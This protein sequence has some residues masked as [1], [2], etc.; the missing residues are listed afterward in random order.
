LKQDAKNANRGTKRGHDAISQSLK[1][2]GA[3]RS[4]LVDKNGVIVAGNKTAQA[5]VN[6]GIDNDAILVQTDGSQL[7]IVQ[8]ADLD[9][10]TDPRAKELALADNRSSELGLEWNVSVPFFPSGM[11][12]L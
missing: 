11:K 12:S 10:P 1:T 7:V 8:R 9:L 4:I 5:A 6:A 3:G 2:L